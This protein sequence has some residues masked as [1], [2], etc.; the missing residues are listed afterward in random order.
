MKDISQSTEDTNAPSKKRAA[1]RSSNAKSNQRQQI[2][3]TASKLFQENG[4]N[5]TSI[6]EIARQIGLNQSSIYYW[7]PSK[8]AILESI[9][10]ANRALSVVERI[11]NEVSDHIVQ[12]YM[13]IVYD[14]VRKCELP[15]DFIEL[16]NL[17]QEN[18][19][20]YQGFLKS[21]REY[22]QAFEK[23][24]TLGI[25]E[26]VFNECLVDEQVVTILSIN[27]G[28]QHHYHGKQRNR[29]ILTTCDY[30]VKDHS[31]DAIGHM[32]A[33]TIIPG[34]LSKPQS[35]DDIRDKALKALNDL[36]I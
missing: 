32:A 4:Y 8:E 10:D 20:K 9:Y 6:S 21:Y 15:F 23:I 14:V 26:G 34:M 22:Y 28:L 31:P 24:I 17:V 19:K 1:S 27:E 30:T 7:F 36:D 2:V 13:L 11:Q 16:E 5:K 3:F 35:I 29:L 18:P 12:L 33:R 25:K